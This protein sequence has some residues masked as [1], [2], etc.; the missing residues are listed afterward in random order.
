MLKECKSFKLV[1]ARPLSVGHQCTTGCGR[2]IQLLNYPSNVR[3]YHNCDLS[4]ARCHPFTPCRPLVAYGYI[5]GT[6]LTHRQYG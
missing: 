4:G 6:L 3:I 2:M 1:T 5:G